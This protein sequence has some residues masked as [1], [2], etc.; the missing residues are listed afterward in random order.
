MQ[1]VKTHKFNGRRYDVV[2]GPLDGWA[3]TGESQKD[4]TLVLNA[5]LTTRKGLITAV[6]ESLHSSNWALGEETVER[7][8]NE[9]GTF[10]WRLGYRKQHTRAV[11]AAKTDG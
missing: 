6:H 4:F 11:S 1:K 5:D 7:M 3:D 9:I 8:A 10:L 2:I